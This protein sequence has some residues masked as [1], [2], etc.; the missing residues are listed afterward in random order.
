MVQNTDYILKTPEGRIMATAKALGADIT[1]LFGGKKPS[2]PTVA[3]TDA[4]Y[5]IGESNT[6]PAD[7]TEPETENESNA[8]DEPEFPVSEGEGEPSEFEQVSLELEQYLISYKESLNV[9]TKNKVNPYDLGMKELDNTNATV[10]SRRSM[11]NRVRDFLIS[12]KVKGV[13]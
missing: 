13:A 7:K 8:D 9:E 12:K 3:E 11:K 1:Q 6:V 10:E 4:E 5:V 2:L